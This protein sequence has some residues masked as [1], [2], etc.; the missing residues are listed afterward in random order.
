MAGVMGPGVASGR[1]TSPWKRDGCEVTA[2]LVAG[3]LLLSPYHRP[4]ALLICGKSCV[5]DLPCYFCNSII[6][7]VD[8]QELLFALISEIGDKL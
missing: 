4:L 6:L 8:L 3:R 7:L 5:C 2:V 1:G